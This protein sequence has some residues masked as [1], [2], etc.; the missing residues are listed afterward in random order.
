MN[1]ENTADASWQST[2]EAMSVKTVMEQIF[3]DGANASSGCCCCF[4]GMEQGCRA[5][6]KANYG[7]FEKLNKRQAVTAESQDKVGTDICQLTTRQQEHVSE[8]P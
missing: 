2:N 5:R 4:R 3:A 7:V 8:K 6:E 1:I